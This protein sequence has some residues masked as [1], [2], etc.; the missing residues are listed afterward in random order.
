MNNEIMI[1]ASDKIGKLLESIMNESS[2]DVLKD[3]LKKVTAIRRYQDTLGEV[4][5]MRDDLFAVE[6]H[7]IIKLA[8]LGEKPKNMADDMIAFFVTNGTDMGWYKTNYPNCNTAKQIYKEYVD[9]TAKE[10][11]YVKGKCVAIGLVSGMDTNDIDRY[12]EERKEELSKSINT[13]L[14]DLQNCESSFSVNDIY[15]DL[16]ISIPSEYERGVKEVIRYSISREKIETIGSKKAPKFVTYYDTNIDAWLRIPFQ[17][18]TI[19]QLKLMIE[20]R[21]KQAKEDLAALKNLKAIYSDIVE[22]ADDEE[23]DRPI[24]KII[25]D[26]IV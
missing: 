12:S 9:F 22:M 23:D 5:K 3:A 13:I 1:S 24:K 17:N 25:K 16:P 8:E 7:C 10:S 15:S 26:K 11:A 21:E 19:N 6:L 4:E 20:L 18:A 14:N 2:A